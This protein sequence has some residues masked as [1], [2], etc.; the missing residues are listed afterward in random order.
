MSPQFIEFQFIGNKNSLSLKHCRII[1]VLNQMTVWVGLFRMCSSISMFSYPSKEVPHCLD[2]HGFII[3]IFF[4][5]R[6]KFIKSN[7]HSQARCLE[8]QILLKGAVLTL[9]KC[10]WKLGSPLP[11][12]VWP[13]CHWPPHI[14]SCGGSS[15]GASAWRCPGE[16][17]QP[18]RAHMAPS[19]AMDSRV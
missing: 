4:P 12:G 11:A 10:S 5:F 3:A 17:V 15:P 2:C 7:I 18:D 1:F 19:R 16:P 9:F 8:L 6:K 13:F 14:W